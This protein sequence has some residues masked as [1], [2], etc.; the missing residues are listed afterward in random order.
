MGG[1][2]IYPLA[3]ILHGLGVALEVGTPANLRTAPWGSSAGSQGSG[4]RLKAESA[5]AGGGA[6]P[7]GPGTV[8]TAAAEVGGGPRGSS[9]CH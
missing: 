1:G 3:S 6:L 7:Q 9:M 2:S 4:E 5:S 8:P